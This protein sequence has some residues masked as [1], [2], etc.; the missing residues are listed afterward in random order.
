MY[1]KIYFD[2]PQ[3]MATSKTGIGVKSEGQLL[4]SGTKGYILAE[5]PWWLTRKFQVR[6]ED[7]NKIETYTPNFLGDGLRYEIG[8]FF[9][10]I[11]GG[12]GHLF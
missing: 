7:S 2:Y 8:E 10:R 9:S 1:T 4:I 11:N 6:Y 12:E 5:S 3:G